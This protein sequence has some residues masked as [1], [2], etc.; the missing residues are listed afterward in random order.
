MQ[1][2]GRCSTLNFF[3]KPWCVECGDGNFAWIDVRPT[4][5]IYSYT[6]SPTVVMNLPGWESDLPVILCLID[7]D[8]GPRMYAQL[9]DCPVQEV[10]I[11]MRVVAHFRKVADDVA[12]PVF[13]PE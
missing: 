9:T 8:D 5:T 1:K 12:I 10:R 11:D 4:G 13:R 7:L 2:C 3:P 6:V